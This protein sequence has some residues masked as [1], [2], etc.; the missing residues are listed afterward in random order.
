MSRIDEE[1]KR[2]SAPFFIEGTPPFR[3]IR[4]TFENEQS[5]KWHLTHRCYHNGTTAIQAL[6]SAA[7]QGEL[8]RVG[9]FGPNIPQGNSVS[10]MTR[11]NRLGQFNEK[12]ALGTFGAEYAKELRCL[13]C[14]RESMNSEL[15]Q[16]KERILKQVHGL[17][18]TCLNEWHGNICTKLEEKGERDEDE[19]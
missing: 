5:A 9:A 8:Q 17:C 4:L 1:L 14:H 19:E 18:V 13:A 2:F 10:I 11:L 12:T 6:R 16:I 3:N 15:A 7:I